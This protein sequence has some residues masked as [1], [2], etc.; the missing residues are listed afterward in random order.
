MDAMSDMTAEE[1]RKYLGN[2][3]CDVCEK[4]A[5]TSLVDMV[6]FY[7]DNGWRYVETDGPVR[8]FA[9]TMTARRRWFHA[10]NGQREAE[11]SNYAR[12]PVVGILALNGTKLRH[13]IDAKVVKDGG[14][15]CVF[16]QRF[17]SDGFKYHW[18]HF[19]IGRVKL[20]DV[21]CCLDCGEVE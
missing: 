4:P 7:G 6:S 10:N 14:F 18:G 15:Y 21:K 17:V 5:V 9:E 2:A 16:C 1:I 20:A 11:M 12:K 19:G 3:I 8:F 13:A